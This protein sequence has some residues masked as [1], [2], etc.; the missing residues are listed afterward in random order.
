MTNWFTN[1]FRK[2]ETVLVAVI[3]HQL[4]WQFGQLSSSWRNV[5]CVLH[6][7]ERSDGE[8]IVKWTYSEHGVDVSP[9]HLVSL[10][11]LKYWSDRTVNLS[12]IPSYDQVKLGTLVPTLT[13]KDLRY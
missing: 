1:L 6:C 10:V 11:I 3:N 5:D 12:I 7:F 9:L 2:K 8:R 4:R 13:W